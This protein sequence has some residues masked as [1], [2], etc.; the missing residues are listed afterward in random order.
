MMS[1]AVTLC[2]ICDVHYFIIT[3]QHCGLKS[4]L[5]EDE[6]SKTVVCLGVM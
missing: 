4:L 3:M 5:K 2:D 1:G 6:A